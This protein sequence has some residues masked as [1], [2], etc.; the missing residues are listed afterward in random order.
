MILSRTL[1]NTRACIA[2]LA[3]IGTAIAMEDTGDI[4]MEDK[5][6]TAYHKSIAEK[7]YQPQKTLYSKKL[8]EEHQTIPTTKKIVKKR[9]L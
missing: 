4:D 8:R 7:I 2:S 1:F 5:G 9:F 6:D 3:F